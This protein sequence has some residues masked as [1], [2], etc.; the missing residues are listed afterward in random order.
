MRLFFLAITCSLL[1]IGCRSNPSTQKE[2]VELRQEILD[3]EEYSFINEADLQRLRQEN[4]ELQDQLDNQKPETDSP[5][6]RGNAGGGQNGPKRFHPA[7]SGQRHHRAGRVQRRNPH[8]GTTRACT[9]DEKEPTLSPY[10]RHRPLA[11]IS[12]KIDGDEGV[13]I[14]ITPQDESGRNSPLRGRT[15]G[16]LDRPNRT[17]PNAKESGY[18]SL[19]LRKQSYSL[20]RIHPGERGILLHLPWEQS[21]PINGSLDLHVRLVTPDGRTLK[22][23]HQLTI[24]PPAAEYSADQFSNSPLGRVK[25]LAGFLPPVNPM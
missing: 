15:Y 20:R 3:W 19:F 24:T 1:A 23:K 25:I 9:Q 8:V 14:F 5:P 7:P 17:P 13:E 16:Q 22:T 12:D 4:S 18:G 21:I 10:T 6:V 11:S 2:I